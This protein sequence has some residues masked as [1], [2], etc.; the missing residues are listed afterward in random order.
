VTSP[1]VKPTQS[2]APEPAALDELRDSIR[3]LRAEVGRRIVGQDRVVEEVLICLLAGGH[4]LLEGVPG[5]A[6]TLLVRSLARGLELEFRRIQFTPDLMPGDV[7]GTEIIEEDRTT[8]HRVFRFVAGPVFT[9]VL[10]ADEINRAPPKTQSAL[11]EAMQENHVTTAGES[12]PIPSP[13]MVLATQNPIEQEGTYPLPEAQLDR[14]LL[15]IRVDYPSWEEEHAILASTTGGEEQEPRPVLGGE[16]VLAL[17]RATRSIPASDAALDHAVRLVRA[18]RPG[19]PDAVPEVTDRLRW[20]AGPRAGQ[21]LVLAGKARALL[22]GRLHLTPEDLREVALP[23]FRHRL[24][25][26]FR[27]EADGLDP[28][29]LVR[30]LLERIPPPASGLG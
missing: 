1:Q 15:K 22:H 7:T 3:S 29:A 14:F 23:V 5:L 16:D 25:P 9:N 4:G 28:D 30:R 6:K 17:R 10:L 26:T 27:A 8:G 21:S 12:R 2:P 18:T 11:L 13:F 19:G 24:V 20:G